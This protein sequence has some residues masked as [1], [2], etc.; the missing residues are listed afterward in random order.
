MSE[1]TLQEPEPLVIITEETSALE[2]TNAIA[3][4]LEITEEAKEIVLQSEKVFQVS[5]E[6]DLQEKA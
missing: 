1:D 2:L 3:D 6:V 4:V 5:D